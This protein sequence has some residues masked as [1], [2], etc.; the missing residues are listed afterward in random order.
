[1]TPLILTSLADL[2]NLTVD[3]I[4]DVRAPTEYAEDHLPNAINLPVLS[5]AKRAEVG[6]IYTQDSPFKARKIGSALV[7]YNTAAHLQGA[8]AD[9]DGAWQ[10]LVVC[11]RGG[12]RSGAFATILDQ[13]S[14]RVQLLKG[15]Y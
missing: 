11:W 4:I 1:M 9:K 10:P 14:W 6:T 3:T 2:Q 7:A 15:G 5:D 8:L 13:V 12:Q